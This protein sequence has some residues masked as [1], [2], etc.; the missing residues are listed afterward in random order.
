M[1]C[2]VVMECWELQLWE[3]DTKSPTELQR[4]RLLSMSPADLHRD[5]SYSEIWPSCNSNLV[6]SWMY[7][8]YCRY[9]HKHL[10]MLLLSLRELY[11][12]LGGHGRIWKW[13]GAWV[14]STRVSGR[15]V[16]G[17]RT[18]LHFAHAWLGLI[19]I[20][21]RLLKFHL[22]HT[23]WVTFLKVYWSGSQLFNHSISQEISMLTENFWLTT[24]LSMLISL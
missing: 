4:S 16:G 8:H 15:I 21:S 22:A 11:S 12:A 17:F 24:L 23:E 3:Y 20:K 5:Q 6:A 9:F 18:D 13:L 19:K 14:R 2:L 7:L 1:T 10:R